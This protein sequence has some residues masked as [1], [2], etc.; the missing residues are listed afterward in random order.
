MYTIARAFLIFLLKTIWGLKVHGKENIPEQGPFILA[1]NHASF[2][3]VPCLAAALPRRIHWVARKEFFRIPLLR[4]LLK[5]TRSIP[6]NGATRE[7]SEAVKMGKILG[8][9]PEGT[10][11]WDGKLQE[12]KK[13][14]AVLSLKTGAPILPVAVTGTFQAYPRTSKFPR[15]IC[16]ISVRF[17][18]PVSFGTADEETIAEDRLKDTTAQIMQKI[19]ELL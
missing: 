9:F 2:L 17:G 1:C 14:I 4:L 5:L 7:A 3:D 8:I 16:P 15:K 12:G 19:A 6:V 18:K 13:G 10:R 11:T